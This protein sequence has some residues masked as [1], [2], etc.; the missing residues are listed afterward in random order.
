MLPKGKELCF[1]YQKFVKNHCPQKIRISP[2]KYQEPIYRSIEL[3]GSQFRPSIVG[4]R[5]MQ[6]QM[7]ISQ[8]LRAISLSRQPIISSKEFYKEIEDQS[9]L[10]YR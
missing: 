8:Q 5:G 9:V 4:H 10:I 7:D 6:D 2:D 1:L 3:P